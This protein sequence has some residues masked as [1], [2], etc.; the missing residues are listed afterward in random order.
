MITSPFQTF[1]F[2]WLG[3]SALAEVCDNVTAIV[4][5]VS[6]IE[7]D[8]V[9]H[10]EQPTEGLTLAVAHFTLSLDTQPRRSISYPSYSRSSLV[11]Y[12][13][14]HDRGCGDVP[15]SV[16]GRE[17]CANPP[18]AYVHTIICFQA[19]NTPSISPPPPLMLLPRCL[20]IDASFTTISPLISPCSFITPP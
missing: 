5:S 19:E 13:H 11:V 4:T 2:G 16:M 12:Q 1:Q 18:Q 6:P 8:V 9:G 14:G 7:L 10:D 3:K 15:R 20:E 17:N